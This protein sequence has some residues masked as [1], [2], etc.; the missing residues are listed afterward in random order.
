MPISNDGGG[1]GSQTLAEVLTTGG[2]PEGNAITGT[3]EVDV[4]EGNN[5]A[6]FAIG[7]TSCLS[8]FRDAGNGQLT[9]NVHDLHVDDG[10]VGPT[11][12]YEDDAGRTNVGSFFSNGDPSGPRFTI[13]DHT[14]A[15]IFRVDA[16]G[17]VHIKT[18]TTIVADL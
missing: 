1:G 5:A 10:V 6:N 14:Q 2:D 7:D 11:W 13:Y 3:L 16:D 8:I 4:A 12:F 18:G 9:V 15:E 17:S